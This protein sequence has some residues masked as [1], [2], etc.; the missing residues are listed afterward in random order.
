VRHVKR[1]STKPFRADDPD[2]ELRLRIALVCSSGGHL[3]ELKRLEPWWQK[4]ECMWVTFDTPDAVS[5]LR[6]ER[7]V[8]AYHPTTRN[9]VNLFRN[10]VLAART[11]WKERPDLVVSDG[12]G[13]A[14][15]FFLVA[16]V[17][18]IKTVF[19]EHWTRPDSPTL[20]GRLCRPLSS[21]FVVQWDEQR[22]H[23][24]GA[25]LIGELW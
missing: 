20:T 2:F 14:V 19:I 8:W 5:L 15:P 22:R 18:R 24:P 12:A 17:L 11:L 7:V 13:V 9:I 21:L 1:R 25:T 23:Y 3:F 10:F 6:G 4:H 16:R